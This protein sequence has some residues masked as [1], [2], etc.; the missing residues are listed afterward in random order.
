[1]HVGDNENGFYSITMAC[2][3]DEGFVTK[4]EPTKQRD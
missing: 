4:A 3:C 2:R 1:M